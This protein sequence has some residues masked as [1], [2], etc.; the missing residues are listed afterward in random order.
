M[1]RFEPHT[2]DLYG[3]CVSTRDRGLYANYIKINM[4][5]RGGN[6][7]FFHLSEGDE[8]KISSPGLNH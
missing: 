1:I 2:D 7:F 5:G 8:L 4:D 6:G 3:P